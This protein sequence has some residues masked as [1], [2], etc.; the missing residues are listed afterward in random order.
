MVALVLGI[1]QGANSQQTGGRID[2]GVAR[3]GVDM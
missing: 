2:S 1:M 3:S